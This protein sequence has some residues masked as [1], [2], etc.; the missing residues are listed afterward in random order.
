MKLKE[1]IRGLE[2]TAIR[3]DSGVDITAI[4]YD[5]RKV[6]PGCLFVAMR[7]E[8]ADGHNYIKDAAAR[9]AVAVICEEFPSGSS[10]DIPF[11]LT[12]V[13]VKDA[14]LALASVANTF[15]MNPSASLPVTAITGTNG[16]TTTSYLLKSML[17]AWGKKVGLIGT[18]RYMI[19]DE[20]F[21]APHTTPESLEFQELL[22]RMRAAGCTHAVSEVSSHALAQSRVDGTAFRAAVFTNLTQDHLD[23]HKTMEEYYRAKERLFTELLPAGGRSIINHDDP[24]GRRLA[25]ELRKLGR[26]V[27]TSGLEAGADLLACEIGTSFTGLKFRIIAEGGK[28]DIISPLVGLPNVY[29]ILSAAGAARALGVPWEAII[30]GIRTSVNVTGRFERVDAGQPF[31]AVVDFAHT[32]DAL[33]R[34]IYTA[35]GLT[36]GRVITVFG[37]GGDRDRGKRPKMGEAATRLSDLVIITSDNPRSEDPVEIIREIEAGAVRR[38]YLV[39]PDREEAIKRAVLMA[40]EDDVVLVAGKGHEQYQE[41]GGSRFSFNDREVLEKSIKR[42]VTNK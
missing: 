5:S 13:S 16:K 32:E 3:G 4:A 30:E 19:G 10:R 12:F 41:I 15:F 21:A 36:R 8:R 38:N 20:T 17:E 24:F 22:S 42:L 2:T 33:Q 14:R 11:A 34:L 27:R 35:K 29:N 39:E 7:G 37:C 40:R 6:T 25:G 23:F 28:Y 1:I 9:G 18:I 31:L 26:D